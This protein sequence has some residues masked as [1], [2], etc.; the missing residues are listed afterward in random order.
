MPG[1]DENLVFWSENCDLGV[2][3]VLQLLQNVPLF[4][5]NCCG[6]VLHEPRF[7]VAAS[8]PVECQGRM[9]NV[10]FRGENCDCRRQR[11]AAGTGLW[12]LWEKKNKF[13]LA[14]GEVACRFVAS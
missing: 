13:P 4:G 2:E 1:S 10:V 12:H 8:S 7:F 9:K 6:V 14:L 3:L 11:L 5:E